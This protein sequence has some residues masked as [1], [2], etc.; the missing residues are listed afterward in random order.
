MAGSTL[1]ERANDYFLR[2]TDLLVRETLRLPGP[3]SIGADRI[4]RTAHWALGFLREVGLAK[5]LLWDQIKPG[6]GVVEVYPVATLEG[7]QERSS[8]NYLRNV[9]L[10][11]ANLERAGAVSV[12]R[13]LRSSVV[14]NEHIF[15]AMLCALAAADFVRGLASS[16]QTL[17]RLSA[18]DGSGSASPRSP[19]VLLHPTLPH[20]Q[21]RL[22]E[23]LA[24]E[25]IGERPDHR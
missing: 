10:T 13:N 25:V 19:V 5:A 12:P 18:R 8:K 17:Q 16:R 11:L 1:P 24:V 7:W 20:R 15:D 21:R 23:P 14:G 22:L 9:D 3:L 6:S 2:T 4:A